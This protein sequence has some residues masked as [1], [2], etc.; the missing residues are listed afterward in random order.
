[1]MRS[2]IGKSVYKGVR[3]GPVIVIKDMHAPVKREKA[4]S[5]EAE[6]QRLEKACG[7]TKSQL[8]KLYHKAVREAGEASAAIFEAHQMMLE[9]EDFLRAIRSM[10][11]TEQVNA[12]YAVAVTGDRFSEMLAGMDDEH[13][14]AR[15]AD[16]K[17]VSNRLLRNLSGQ[18]EIDWKEMEPAIIIAEDLS[19][20]ETVRMDK[21][22]ILAL[23]TVHGSSNS[24]TAILA[25]TMG[26]PALIGV[27]FDES[28]DGQLAILDGYFCQGAHHLNVNVMHRETLIDAMDHPEKYPSLTIRV[29]GYAV[30]FSRGGV[31]AFSNHLFKLHRW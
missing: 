15:A 1:M 13:M 30:N 21:D 4:E 31:R 17:D 9:D 28:W 12:E 6:L 10:I 7:E 25:R 2:Y 11:E 22:K 29:S 18:K 16:I 20:S 19:P 8:Q 5:S 24:H 26:I 27:D 14:K 23:V 3:L